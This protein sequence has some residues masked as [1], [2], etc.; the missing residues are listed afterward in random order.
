MKQIA[1]QSPTSQGWLIRG[2]GQPVGETSTLI[3]SANVF[4]RQSRALSTFDTP[5]HLSH[6]SPG[7]WAQTQIDT[8]SH[9]SR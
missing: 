6:P 4:V 2:F 3:V 9:G 5:S 7:S 1:L 8:K